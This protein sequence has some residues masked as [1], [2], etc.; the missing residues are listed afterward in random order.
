MD[1]PVD[2]LALADWRR[3][4][5]SLYGRIRSA[6]DPISAWRD[7]RQTRDRLFAGHPQSPIPPDD[8]AAFSGLPCYDYDPALR[9]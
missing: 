5:A 7:W 1:R 6:P 3:Q 8:R 4:I 2:V 9:L